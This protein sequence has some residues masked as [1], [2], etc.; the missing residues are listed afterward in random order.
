MI[1]TCVYVSVKP[2]HVEDFKRA[3]QANHAASVQEAG[4]LRFDV[5]QL[6]EDPTQFLLYEAYES[7][8]HA[9]AHKE[10]EHY[11][12]W[13]AT[14]AEWMAAPRRGVRYDGIAP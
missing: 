6:Q 9:A 8:E 13:R 1:V 3:S 11:L 10:T 7:A 2:E 5:L 14:V 12:T 4:N